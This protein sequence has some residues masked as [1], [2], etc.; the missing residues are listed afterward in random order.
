MQHVWWFMDVLGSAL[1]IGFGLSVF[2]SKSALTIFSVLLIVYAACRISWS[3]FIKIPSAIMM[4]SLYPIALL[5]NCFSVGGFEIVQT[6]TFKWALPLIAIPSVYFYGRHKD[7]KKLMYAMG[8][9][10]LIAC[11][12]S[13]FILFSDFKA[14]EYS[15]R[16]A[17]FWDIARW[18]VFLSCT[19]VGIIALLF[20]ERLSCRVRCSALVLLILSIL[21]LILTAARGPWIATILGCIMLAA[22]VSHQKLK[23]FTATMLI[24]ILVISVPQVRERLASSWQISVTEKGFESSHPSNDGRLRMWKVGLSAFKLAPF[25]GSGYANSRVLVEQ[26]INTDPEMAELS[27]MSE[28][29]V[30]DLHSSYLS[31]LVQMGALF[32]VVFFVFA[33]YC[34]SIGFHV[35]WKSR[36]VVAALI[37]SIS[38]VQLIEFFI[39]SSVE[40][41]EMLALFPFWSIMSLLK[42]DI[43]RA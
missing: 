7:L 30:T 3:E 25:F 8:V 11:S 26:V 5:L 28:F 22:L 27:Q 1:I 9:S 16:V 21:S 32:F 18:A 12:Y 33:A 20:S 37:L 10:L 24:S 6:E 39:Y 4:L 38:A 36:S 35:W 14:F 15:G 29:S 34:L 42:K 19:I 31:L 41:Y 43:V 13:F 23:F 2:T 17:S 40:S